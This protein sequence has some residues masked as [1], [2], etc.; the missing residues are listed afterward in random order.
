MQSKGLS[1]AQ[2]LV[3]ALL[4][5]QKRFAVELDEVVT[6][7]NRRTAFGSSSTNLVADASR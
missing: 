2:N 1:E 7:N 5:A 3:R 6:K 4:G